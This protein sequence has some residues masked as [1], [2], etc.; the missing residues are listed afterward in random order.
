[1]NAP[2]RKPMTVSEFLAWAEARPDGCRYL[3][4]DG[5]PVEMA[6]QR[7][8]HLRV[9]GL[10]FLALVEAAEAL[11]VECQVLPD[12]IMVQV[13]EYTP[14]EPDA[15]VYLG[16]PLDDDALVLP[17]PLAVFEVLSPRTAHVDTGAKLAGYFRVASLMHY[18][19]IDPVKRRVLRHSRGAGPHIDTEIIESGALVLD[20]PGMTFPIDRIFPS[21]RRLG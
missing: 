6:P 11:H 14:Y 20:P 21:R 2:F 12:G 19:I 9:K 15:S 3:L 5:E 13:D 16:P 17:N 8:L 10:L 1:M 18:V 7:A 4:I